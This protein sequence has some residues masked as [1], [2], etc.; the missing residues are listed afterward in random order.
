MLAY[1]PHTSPN[2]ACIYIIY[3]L[4]G[5]VE[6]GSRNQGR[7]RGS[8]DSGRGGAGRGGDGE[9]R[10]RRRRPGKRQRRGSWCV[11]ATAQAQHDAL[12]IVSTAES[13]QLTDHYCR[14]RGCVS[15]AILAKTT[16]TLSS[17]FCSVRFSCCVRVAGAAARGHAGGMYARMHAR[18]T[19]VSLHCTRSVNPILSF[20]SVADIA[21]TT[22]LPLLTGSSP[23]A[24]Q[25]LSFFCLDDCTMNLILQ[26][27]HHHTSC[28]R[29]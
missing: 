17:I 15:A 20:L 10:A 21:T 9:A 27:T 22:L 8:E 18:S 26:H 6:P 13:S 3:C 16:I 4:A 11:A 25:V 1:H 12:H 24:A 19:S 23:A 2:H 7:C 28:K 14:M 5:R 29:S